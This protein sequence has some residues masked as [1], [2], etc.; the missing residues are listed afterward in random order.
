MVQVAVGVSF[1][2]TVFTLMVVCSSKCVS[3]R[4]RRSVVLGMSVLVRLC[5]GMLGEFESHTVQKVHEGRR[6]L[7]YWT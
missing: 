1:A 2:A 4:A 6:R 3:I 7:D 5:I